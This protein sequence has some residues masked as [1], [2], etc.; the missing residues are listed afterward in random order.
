MRSSTILNKS[1]DS[2]EFDPSFNYQSVIGKMNYLEKGPQ[3]KLAYGIHQCARY[4]TNPRKDHGDAVQ[5]IGRYFLGTAKD[6]LILKPDLA[7]SFKVFVDSYFCGNWHKQYAGEIDSVR[8]R[9]GYVIK[10]AGCPFVSKSQLQTEIA[11]STTEAE[12][13]GIS[14][15][16]REAIP[17][18]EL[19]KEMKEKGFDVLDH[20]VKFHCRVFEDNSGAIEMAV[21]HKWRPRTKNLAKNC[22]ISD[23]T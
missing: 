10:Y 2:P 22:I 18:M 12:Y 16:L 17:L 1:K 7:K 19:L 20:K 13:T 15:A 9:H 3:S 21:V 5:W 8:L 6:G 11:L 4:S 23:P 14:Y